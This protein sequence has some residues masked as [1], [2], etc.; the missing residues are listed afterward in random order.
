MRQNTSS[1][2]SSLPFQCFHTCSAPHL[3]SKTAVLFVRGANHNRLKISIV[4]F[5][6]NEDHTNAM[7][8]TG[9]C[10][11]I[12]RFEAPLSADKSQNLLT[13]YF[14]IAL[15]DEKSNVVD[16]VWYS[17]LGMS[18]EPPLMQHCYSIELFDPHPQWAL[19]SVFYQ[20]FPD[21]FASSRGYFTVDGNRVQADAPIRNKD[22][23]FVNIDETH[24]GGDLDGVA[25]MLPYIRSLGCD[26]IYLTPVFK[27]PSV[28]KFDTEDYDIVDPHF[29]GNG[30]LKRLRT[31]ALGYE[32]KIIM[33]GNFNHTGD[34]HP[35]FDRQERTGKGALR[36]K[37]SPYREMY[38]FTSEGEAYVSDNKAN[39]PKL[40]YANYLTCHAIF[41]G[42]NSIVKK[43]I[44]S[45][46][47][48][49][50]WVIDHASQIGDNGSAKN[51]LKRLSQI[52]K[53]ARSSH[54][55]C[56]M[57]GQFG[58]DPRYAICSDGNVDGTINY[59]GFISPI[60]SFFGG[61][62]LQ[63]DPT[64]YTG[65]DLKRSCEEFSVGV[66]QQVKLCL[67][68]QLDNY[69][70]PRFYD[71][72][73][74]DKYMYLSALAC[75]FT[76]RGIPCLYQGDELGDVLDKYE[77]GP[78]GLIPFQAL[79]DRHVSV[80]SNDVQSVITEL[81]HL[82]RSN[83]AFSKGSMLFICAGG[84]YFGY[85]RL[86]ENRF[87]IVLVNASRQ[88]VK[89]EQGSMLFPLLA[90]IYMPEDCG[91]DDSADSG[92]DLL[93]PLSGRNV[94][95]YDHGGGLEGLYDMLARE[96]ISVKSYGATRT[97]PEY[98][99]KFLKELTQGKTITIPPRSTVIAGN[100]K[101]KA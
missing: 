61:V 50:G 37:D 101:K 44:R 40:D 38:T 30:A 24:C 60:R 41:D 98:E 52:C 8:Y 56:L 57:L 49:D 71:I 55:D 39:Y 34:S 7:T 88:Q 72:I 3:A 77:V 67:I 42:P 13:Y 75:L 19:D 65:E 100:I 51:N 48:I 10:S 93:I 35:W 78:R 82:R 76:W 62:N 73:G 46:Y 2:R 91:S 79:K 99:E 6:Q 43:W 97:S 66:S 96:T 4:T 15:T 86:F 14:K 64:P 29:G 21:K 80:N 1:P 18:R 90:A 31:V 85:I 94:R 83:P 70:L 81:S 95:R 84:A 33:H 17:S 59:T 68:N 20:I 63:G 25:A 47:S 32:M 54:L 28:H 87:S 45:P 89:I 69:K 26:S 53:S 12:H 5:A 9:S 16:V 11:G 58:S 36:H 22:F 92:E 23:E 74:A 27:S